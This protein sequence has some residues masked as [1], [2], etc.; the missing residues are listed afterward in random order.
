MN[1]IV[2]RLVTGTVLLTAAIA[3]TL[4]IGRLWRAVAQPAPA[5]PAP[6]LVRPEW[7]RRFVTDRFNPF[8]V[9]L[10]LVGGRRSPWGYLEHVG[11]R[12]GHVHR[13]PV[14]PRVIGDFAYVPLAYGPDVQW[15]RNVRTA[16]TC[17]LQVHESV[18]EL[19][20]P[21]TITAAEHP[22]VAKA[23]K[24]MLERRG[25]R[26]VRLHVLSVKP[27]TLDERSVPEPAAAEPIAGEVAESV[28]AGPEVPVT[29]APEPAAI[30]QR[31][32]VDARR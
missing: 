18:Y 10:G 16:G 4:G 28:A 23:F 12:T 21:V 2:A 19:D 26:Y 20:E 6:P 5:T 7:L 29:E 1:R 31:E 9:G 27:G 30:A 24:P 8:V 13:T 25:D 15:A 11:R 3:V 22:G 32:P 14:L 17:R